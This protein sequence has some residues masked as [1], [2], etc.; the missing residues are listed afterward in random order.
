MA[1]KDFI[2]HI[3]LNNQQLLNA[4]LQNLAAF[5][6]TGDRTE[7]FM[8]WH[9]GEDTAY[10]YTGQASPNEWL[11]LGEVYTHPDFASTV[12]DA[13]TTLANAK[14]VSK[15][16]LNNGHITA[17]ET[18]DITP[19]DIGAAPTLHEHNYSD[20]IDLPANTILA[21]DTDLTRSA[22]AITV[23]QMLTMLSI[24]YG[25]YTILN[26]GTDTAN[27]T[28]KAADL[29]Q[30]I[31]ERI[32][33]LDTSSN[34]GLGTKTTTT[35]PITNDNGSGVTLPAA[36]TSYAGLFE[37]LD[38]AKLDGVESG[39]NKYEHPA[40]STLNEVGT[41]LTGL[42]VLSKLVV[43]TNGH[44]TE[45]RKRTITAA[46]LA[47]VIFDDS[48]N[49][50]TTKGWTASKI[51]QEVG[52]AI[53]QAK[54]GGLQYKGEYDPT[55]NTPDITTTAAAGEDPLI[56]IG[57]TY[58][59]AVAGTFVT[60]PVEVGDMIIAKVDDPG[61]TP[62]N[63]Q[64]VNKNIEDVANASTT[65]KGIIEIATNTEAF[66]GTATNLAIVPSS[67]KHVLTKLIGSFVE[68]IGD[69][70]STSFTV[71]HGLSSEMVHVQVKRV[72]DNRLI[73]TQVSIPDANNVTVDCNVAPTSGQYEVL[74][75]KVANYA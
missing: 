44:V 19:G 71:A 40:H 69:G 46:E 41:A 18:R 8:F 36:T 29:K 30:Y 52:N 20:I 62:E 43:A 26:T 75:S 33:A 54:T 12:N 4:T 27:R 60:K 72:S 25:S 53:D 14:V 35:I 37:A 68:A 9:T 47:A 45:A 2:V 50:S 22:K 59:V 49:T 55:T 63:W 31:A 67:L 1:K 61:T 73:E 28:W 5:P 39:A 51:Y 21:N 24:S 17:V 56:L 34:L 65:L 32:A 58:V 48:S 57:Y 11:D 7:G 70:A 3:D 10:V 13:S 74:V 66:A 23:D 15:I 6:A 16:T 38:K 64:I 42:S